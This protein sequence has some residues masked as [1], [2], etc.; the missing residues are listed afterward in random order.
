MIGRVL[1]ACFLNRQAA[2]RG[3]LV[4]LRNHLI[5]TSTIN[6]TYSHDRDALVTRPLTCPLDIT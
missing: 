3:L 1:K 6:S 5:P 2:C 4:C